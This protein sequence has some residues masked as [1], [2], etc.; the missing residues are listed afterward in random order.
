MPPALRGNG[1]RSPPGLDYT[2]YG[3]TFGSEVEG[4]FAFTES[5]N[6]LA[7]VMNRMGR[8]YSFDVIRVGMLCDP[9]ARAM[10]TV[11]QKNG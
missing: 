5:T 6:S 9:K 3:T 10:G 4:D 2:E 1:S 11:L 8:G 7:K